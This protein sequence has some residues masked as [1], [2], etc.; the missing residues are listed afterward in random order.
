MN[1][2]ADPLR[3]SAPD[4]G[5]KT[6]PDRDTVC[7]V[8]VAYMNLAYDRKIPE[9][10]PGAHPTTGKGSAYWPSYEGSIVTD[11]VSRLTGTTLKLVQ[12]IMF[13]LYWATQT[14][15]ISD[16]RIAKPYTY[17]LHNDT[18]NTQPKGTDLDKNRS[19]LDFSLTDLIR[20]GLILGVVGVGVYAVSTVLTSGKAVAGLLKSS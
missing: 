2:Y 19:W 8:F 6:F 9:F 18:L 17:R 13:E 4:C 15:R 10:T 11:T 1:H 16:G 5:I 14:G 3:P 12:E 20:W 7:Q